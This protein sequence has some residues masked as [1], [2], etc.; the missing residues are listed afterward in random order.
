MLKNC[1]AGGGRK[2]GRVLA[3]HTV[4]LGCIPG[5]LRGLWSPSGNNT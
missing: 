2:L 1:G 5:I 3:V 4:D